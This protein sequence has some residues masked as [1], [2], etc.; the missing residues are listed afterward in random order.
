[1][2]V[3]AAIATTGC[4]KDD[5]DN[6]NIVIPPVA[7]EQSPMQGY[8]TVA[9]F[10]Q[11][12]SNFINAGTYEFGVSFTPKANGKITAIS[13]KIP[14]AAPGTRVTI[15]QVSPV[16]VLRTESID[17]AAADT[18]VSKTITPLAVQKDKQYA[19]TYSGNDWYKRSKTD[20]T[21]ATYPFI[22]GDIQIDEYRWLGVT[23]QTFPTNVSAN[24]YGGDCFFKFVKD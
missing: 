18:E 14:D 13:M 8:I 22:V 12:T 21:N 1:M 19:I 20:N 6:N 3:L 7:V 17:I 5:D 16:A 11:A 23:T 2:T 15:W 10:D 9:G 4:S 24:Y